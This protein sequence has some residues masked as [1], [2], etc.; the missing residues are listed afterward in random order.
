MKPGQFFQRSEGFV[1]LISAA[2]IAGI[3]WSIMKLRGK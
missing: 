2:S 1:G 3:I